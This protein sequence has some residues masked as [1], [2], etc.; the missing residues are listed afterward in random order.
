MNTHIL[1]GYSDS[2]LLF[3]NPPSPGIDLEA[4]LEKYVDTTKCIYDEVNELPAESSASI[5][6]EML[7]R[8]SLFGQLPWLTALADTFESPS[9]RIQVRPLHNTLVH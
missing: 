4:L 1:T 6:K 3:L 7:H 5:Y 8:S 2:T 9:E